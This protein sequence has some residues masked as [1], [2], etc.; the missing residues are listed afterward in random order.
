[1]GVEAVIKEFQTRAGVKEEAMGYIL[2]RSHLLFWFANG[3]D[4]DAVLSIPWVVA[5][6]P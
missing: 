1:M 5:M 3:G 4:R 2:D 6:E